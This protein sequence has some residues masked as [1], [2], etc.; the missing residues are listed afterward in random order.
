MPRGGKR[1]GAGRPRGSTNKVTLDALENVKAS[2]ESPLEY[3]CSVFRATGEDTDRRIKAA[4]AAA[5]YMHTRFQDI[6]HSGETFVIA[7]QP[8]LSEDEWLEQ[9]GPDA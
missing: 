9:H 4:T 6:Q 2:G 7:A 3:L 5:P 1:N 8:D